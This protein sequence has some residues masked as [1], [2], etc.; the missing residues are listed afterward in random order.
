MSDQGIRNSC[1]F[2]EFVCG[3]EYY[4]AISDINQLSVHCLYSKHCKYILC[5]TGRTFSK[6]YMFGPLNRTF[7]WWFIGDIIFGGNLIGKR[8]KAPLRQFVSSS[9]NPSSISQPKR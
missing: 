6:K 7:N 4:D 5:Y 3:P 1:I 9:E 2:P 8:S